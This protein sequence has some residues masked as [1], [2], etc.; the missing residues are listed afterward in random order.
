LF[1]ELFLDDEDNG[2]FAESDRGVLLDDLEEF[3]FSSFSLWEPFL[4]AGN[5]FKDNFWT[6]LI[7]SAWIRW[8]TP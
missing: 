3:L 7:K 4:V 1:N 6:M 5:T 2:W 8:W